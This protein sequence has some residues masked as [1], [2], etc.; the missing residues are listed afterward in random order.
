MARQLYLVGMLVG[1]VGCHGQS[2][3]MT[4]PFLTPD[5]V[6]PP[7]TRVLAP[8]TAQPYYP[9][10]PMP[11]ASSFQ[12]PAG[13]FQS[14][15]APPAG[16]TPPGG[17]N[18]SYQQSPP[19][20]TP[21]QPPAAAPPA[22][23]Y[24]VTPTS[25][26][27]G[28]EDEN[29]AIVPLSGDSIQVPGD[30]QQARL[31]WGQST[32]A[33]QVE[34]PRIDV[35]QMSQL[36]PVDSIAAQPRVPIQKL[37]SDPRGQQP[38]SP[39]NPQV[40]GGATLSA[41]PGGPTSSFADGGFQQAS[42][43]EQ[44]A[45]LSAGS[46]ARLGG[47]GFRPRGTTPAIAEGDSQGFRSPAIT[48]AGVE[49]AAAPAGDPHYGVGEQ[50]EWLRGQLVLDGVTG[51]MFVQYMTTGGDPYGGALP[52]ANP[53]VVA[54]LVPGDFVRLTGQ[55]QHVQRD[56]DTLMPVFHVSGVERQVR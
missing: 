50:Y 47:D 15:P 40:F 49:A 24:G 10:D 27:L 25:A 20:S 48:R 23:G 26:T 46:I 39:E 18:N 1:L 11:G 43:S 13:G 34:P 6:P 30:N 51:M 45:T 56:D 2:Q 44:T 9:G 5:R 55:L 19:Q 21:Y 37:L 31:P 42:Y 53:A 16:G 28:P 8:G 41:A 7:Q 38:T 4:N 29:G 33:P 35:P 54:N 17:W 12:A 36:A 3:T 32:L 52:L 14:P 22:Y